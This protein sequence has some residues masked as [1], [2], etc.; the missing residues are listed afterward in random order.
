M[1]SPV[2]L[3][4]L[5]LLE[6]VLALLPHESFKFDAALFVDADANVFVV[7]VILSNVS[8]GFIV[9]LKLVL[10]EGDSEE[11]AI[12]ERGGDTS[13]VSLWLLFLSMLL[14]TGFWWVEVRFLPFEGELL[15]KTKALLLCD[16]KLFKKMLYFI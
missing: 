14:F 11:E 16:L 4:W 9:D 3:L 8:C 5:W 7:E 15:F 2:L 1:N 12:G 6:R 13:G 10:P